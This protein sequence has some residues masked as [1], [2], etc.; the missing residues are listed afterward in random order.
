MGEMKLKTGTGLTEHGIDYEK[1]T[2]IVDFRGDYDG[3]C[4]RNDPSIFFFVAN[5]YRKSFYVLSNHIEKLFE[6]KDNSKEIEHLILPYVFSFRHYLELEFK[7]IITS[8]TNEITDDTH[9]L[10]DL[11]NSLEK[12]L[13]AVSE[14]K[15]SYRLFQM[16]FQEN[17]G[18]ALEVYNYIKK[19]INNFLAL[20]PS[21]EYYR[22]LFKK[23]MTLNDPVLS[24]DFRE[25]DNLFREIDHKFIELNKILREMDVYVYFTL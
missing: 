7:A 3:Q 15:H 20:E 13:K 24:L 23:K 19:L 11:M 5:S 2:I 6:N 9:S 8:M 21:I 1:K 10:K 18:K 16:N 22:Y 17:K 25:S 4:Y 14:N 12:A